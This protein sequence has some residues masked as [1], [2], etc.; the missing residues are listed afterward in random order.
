MEQKDLRGLIGYRFQCGQK[1]IFGSPLIA[2]WIARDTA[3][4]TDVQVAQH[5]NHLAIQEGGVVWKRLGVLHLVVVPQDADNFGRDLRKRL[6]HLI[7]RSSTAPFVAVGIVV[8]VAAKKHRVGSR[9]DTFPRQCR[10]CLS[11][12]YAEQPILTAGFSPLRSEERRVGKES[13]SR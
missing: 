3:D 10:K 12:R 11:H 4:A 6:E 8:Q 5:P 7:Y 13:R 9:N 1:I 2:I